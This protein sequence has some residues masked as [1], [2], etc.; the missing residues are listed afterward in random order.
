MTNNHAIIYAEQVTKKQIP[1][2]KYV[3]KQCKEFLNIAKGKNKKYVLDEKKIEFIEKV[4]NILIMPKG[5][6]AGQPL[7]KCL[8]GFQWLLIIAV[9]ATVHKDNPKK[10]R[11]ETAVLEIAR[12]EGKTLLVGV[13]FILLFLL[14]PKFSKF[15]SVAPDGALSREVKDAIEN[16][17]KSSPALN[18]LYNNKQKF[19]ILRDSIKFSIKESEYKP[20]AYSNNR[21]DGKLPNV[22]LADEVGALPNNSAIESMRSGQLTI[23]NKLGFIISTKYPSTSN[24][25]E[26]EVEYAKKIL[27]G[28]IKNDSVFALLYE[29]DSKKTWATNDTIIKHANPL[30]LEIPAIMQDLKQ[31]RQQAIEQP[32]RRENFLCKHLNI[33]HQST[34]E[35]YVSIDDLKK[36][37][38]SSINWQ[39]REVFV[40]LDLSM[41]G[42]N[43]AVTFLSFDEYG[44]LLIMP[45]CFI[46]AGRIEEKSK[47][48]KVDYKQFIEAGQVIACGDSVINYGDIEQYILSI[49]NQ[50]NVKINSIGYDRYN[51]I[52]TANKLQSEGLE[53]VEIKQHSSVLHA[54]IKLLS[55]LISNHKVKFVC[56]DLYIENFLNARCVYDTNMNKYLNKKKSAGKIDMVMATVNALYLAQQAELERQQAGWSVQ[57]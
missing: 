55:E 10:R 53:C 36:C 7:S 27:D 52:S 15:Y 34:A 24:P 40:G 35:S 16:I 49:E 47:F 51:A 2:P 1:A 29:P 12:K 37:Q 33:I 25:M 42:D 54:P 6:R 17:I 32:S 56:N 4:L 46:P 41:S 21:L 48:E 9:L 44:D 8:A 50:Y 26:D 14:E 19:K 18:G 30:A 31:K 45:M 3:V 39:G 13:I 20:L 5:L 38:V 57:I 28:S 23:L 11:Y 43:T 22:F